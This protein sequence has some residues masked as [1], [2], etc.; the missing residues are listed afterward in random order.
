MT[1]SELLKR[2]E[3]VKAQMDDLEEDTQSFNRLSIELARLYRELEYA[4]E[5]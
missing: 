3:D 4:D 1:K 2:I 5:D